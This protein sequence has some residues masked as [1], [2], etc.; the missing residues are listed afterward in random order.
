MTVSR[1]PVLGVGDEIRLGGQVH[2]VDTLADGQVRL[3][4][5]AGVA[6]VMPLARLLQ[7]H[8]H[9]STFLA[10]DSCETVGVPY[11]AEDRFYVPTAG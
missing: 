6:V 9:A 10:D 8:D 1:P 11:R 2:V 3:L 4:D 5:V 7:E